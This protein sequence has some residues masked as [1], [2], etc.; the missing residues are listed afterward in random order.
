[1]PFSNRE[2]SEVY[3]LNLRNYKLQDTMSDHQNIQYVFHKVSPMILKMLRQLAYSYILG[4]KHQKI[5]RWIGYVATQSHASVSPI[6]ATVSHVINAGHPAILIGK[7]VFW[8]EFL[9]P[10]P[11]CNTASFFKWGLIVFDEFPR[12]PKKINKNTM[13]IL[14]EMAWFY[15]VQTLMHY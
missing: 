4:Y 6:W 12:L 1:M 11:C 14:W 5:L 15:Y 9:Y 3:A 2:W 8:I 10:I 7:N 13:R